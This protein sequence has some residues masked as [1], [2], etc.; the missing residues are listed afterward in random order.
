MERRK[1]SFEDAKILGVVVHG[2][3][4]ELIE[5][6]NNPLIKATSFGVITD[7]IY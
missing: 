6:I 2:T 7:P 1:T 5:L 3:K 4:E